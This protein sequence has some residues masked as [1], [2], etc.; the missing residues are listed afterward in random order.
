MN[1]NLPEELQST[2]DLL[3][4]SLQMHATE[5]SPAIPGDL[6]EDLV[7][8]FNREPALAAQTESKSWFAAIQSFIARPAFGVAA[9]A[10]VIL[11]LVIPSVMRPDRTESGFR[12][13]VSDTIA[14]ESARIILVK[15]SPE[16]EQTLASSGD[17]EEGV[18]SSVDRLDA[19]TAGARVVVDFETSTIRVL[20][21]SGEEIHSAPVPE[22]SNEL[23]AAIASAL[24]RL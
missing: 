5:K 14:A 13:A 1:P 20:N 11:G 17:F 23:S 4:G 18:I 10:V 7:L 12:G 24:S 16:I 22:D 9:L 19:A 15:A 8:R 2:R 3:A 6:L 21:A